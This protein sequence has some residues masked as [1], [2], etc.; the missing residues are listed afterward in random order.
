MRAPVHYDDHD[1][2]VIQ[3]RGTKRWYI[4]SK[5]SKLPNAWKGISDEAPDLGPHETVDVA[6]GDILYLP[7]GTFH[8]VD[9][10][11]ESL[12]LAMGFTPLTVRD[13]VIAVLDHLSDLDESLRATIGGRIASQH[14][15]SG[16][17]RLGPSVLDGAR[18]LLAACGSQGFVAEALQRRSART[19]GSL[20]ALPR[21][22]T[23]PAINLGTVLV[24]RDT[25][26]CHLTANAEKIDFSYPGGHLYIHR[27]AQESVVYIV[28]TSTFRIG[29]IPGHI[30][31]DVRLSLAAKFLE[32]GFLDV[33][34][35][36]HE[37]PS[38]VHGFA[39]VRKA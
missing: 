38:D 5:P 11:T 7:R 2:I 23:T 28:N 30:G 3:L 25:G 9:S 36:L 20:E 29:D 27:G 16:F 33:A 8:S 22:E 6:P 19:V 32:V 10:E 1:L 35:A 12:H 31:D 17:E 26:F 21:P 15:G 14:K 37:G 4:S 24:Q 39:L 13:A 18:R 34:P